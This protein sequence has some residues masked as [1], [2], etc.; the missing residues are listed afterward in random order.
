MT[1]HTSVRTPADV[2]RSL[3]D[4]VYRSR[5]AGP[6]A[7]LVD[8]AAP[9][10]LLDCARVL[11]L[12]AGFPDGR[13][14]I[15]DSVHETD[16]VVLRL[17]LRGT[18][19]GPTAGHGPT[20]RLLALPVFG[21]YR[22]ANARI[23]DAWQAWDTGE[24]GGPPTPAAGEP[25]VDLDELQGNVFPG[26]NKARLAVVQFAITDTAAAGRALA[27]FADQVATAAEVLPFNRL[28]SALRSRRGAEPVSSTWCNVALSYPALR[29]LT[30]GAEQFADAG[31]R[32]GMR[33]RMAAA[34]VDLTSWDDVA[35]ADVLLLVASDDGDR[36]R[37][38]VAEAAGL[39]AP[40]L[41][42]VAEEYGA[43]QAGQEP[44]GFRD[45]VSQPGLRGR[46][47]DVPW[48]PLTP[49]QNP[50]LPDEGKP[51]QALVWP[52]EFVFGYPAQP[53]AGTST[54]VERSGAPGWAR[55]G[56]FLV[57]GRFRQDPVEFRRFTGAT[58]ERLAA[59]EPSL[60]GLTEERLAA[61]LVG[62]W[63]SGAPTIRAPWADDPAMA[64]DRCADN[65]FAYRSP[66]QPLGDAT[67]GLCGGG[68]F[69][70]APA[71]PGGL[72]CPYSAHIRKSNPRDDI[73]PAE[74][75]RHRMLRRGIPYESSVDDRERG[76][77][78]LSY[79]TSIEQ[80]FEFVMEQW[81]ANPKFRAPDE[82]EDLI[83]APVFT[84]RHMFGLRVPSGDGVRTIPLEPERPWT[85][86]TG[87]GYFFTPSISTLR[88]LGGQ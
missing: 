50:V 21:S 60:A 57:Y 55:N 5:D 63:R 74:A 37:A 16:S 64:H 26:F 7:G 12:L 20:G 47:S 54:P 66:R 67:P 4:T 51:G 14:E 35:A 23:V 13:L 88:H 71:D 17:T 46:R 76:L 81:L 82:G 49:R 41:R 45:G 42:P 22:V 15:E 65:D 75:Q 70:P 52:G 69:P 87:G 61:L 24:I 25:L 44:F 83:V 34:G 39:L 6:L 18:Q 27:A 72:A 9:D 56:S 80:Q 58:A 79:Q 68:G 85:A 10:A 77:L 43:R 33:P 53:A 1:V 84:G 62:R 2:V 32:S 59:T 28:F 31:F 73:A 19:T 48:E 30:A 38:Q 86:L 11:A 29:A 36:L 8:P 78:F 40:G 3:I